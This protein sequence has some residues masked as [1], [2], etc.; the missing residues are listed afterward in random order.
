MIEVPGLP[1]LPDEF[2]DFRRA[3]YLIWRHLNLPPPTRV[4]LDIAHF[5]Q[6][7]PRRKIIQAFR[8]VGKSWITSAYVDWLLRLNP[9]LNI[10][11][12]SASKERADNFSTFTLQLLYGMD[13][14]QCL[15]PRSNQRES[16]VAFDVAPA[17]ADHAPS[18]KSVGI[19]G[20]MTG[21]RADIIIA[22]DIE[23][24]NNS[25][26][27][28][29]RD[30]LSEAVKEFDAILKPGGMI[31]YLGTPQTE[32]TV[33][34]VLPER[35][36]TKRVWPARYPTG[37]ELEVYWADLAPM[38]REDLEYGHAKEAEPTDAMRFNEED[39]QEREASYGRSGF[40][41]QYMLNTALSD[42]DRYPLKLRDLIVYPLSGEMAPEKLVWAADHRT[43]LEDLPNVGMKGDRLYG[44]GFIAD[45]YAPYTGCILA[46][47]PS[48]RGKD[49]TTYA[50]IKMLHGYLFL[51]EAGGFQDG[52]DDKVL[53]NL[54][55][56]AKKHEAK[57]IIIESNFGDGMFTRL[58]QPHLQRIYPC[59][60]E[61]VR[62][63]I[64]KERRIIDT[65]E[66]VMNQHKLVVNRQVILDDYESVK[67]LPPEQAVRRRLFY[68]MTRLTSERGSLAHDDRIDVLAIGVAYWVE[69]M[70]QD[71]DKRISQRREQE[72][73]EELKVFTGESA[74]SPDLLIMKNM[75]IPTDRDGNPYFKK[76]GRLP[77][78]LSGS[79]WLTRS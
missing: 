28:L 65:L 8:G 20:Q 50:V 1:P 40:A 70:G 15:I 19:F 52:Y 68:Q 27:Q 78:G 35:G 58:L 51:M 7:G 31:T 55:H 48:G 34:S 3:L 42:Q 72:L 53:Q 6:H 18:V 29:K 61:E 13:V 41:L 59:T 25:E 75:P 71:A 23:V 38:L 77:R 5:L 16:K 69:Q 45:K 54:C 66:P 63:S 14:F 44:P 9:Q 43:I 74:L 21:S 10:L 37:K 32:E 73:M 12:V 36:Y 76:T 30:K 26:T 39:L 62:H 11:V 4:Q 24:A 64:Q 49:E 79:G 56:I 22:D 67:H 17:E 46:I 2:G 33:Y 57:R 60:C 47:D